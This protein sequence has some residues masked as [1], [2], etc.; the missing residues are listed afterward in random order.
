MK[1]WE[2]RR[3]CPQCYGGAVRRKRTKNRQVRH[4]KWFVYL[5]R[6]IFSLLVWSKGIQ[7]KR[8]RSAKSCPAVNSAAPVDLRLEKG[9]DMNMPTFEEIPKHAS[10]SWHQSLGNT[11][12][13]SRRPPHRYEFSRSDSVKESCN[14]NICGGFLCKLWTFVLFI[15]M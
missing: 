3:L 8:R 1:T 7:V 6:F 15:N 5:E 11:Q 4:R 2:K 12:V 9:F 13:N 10:S 14:R